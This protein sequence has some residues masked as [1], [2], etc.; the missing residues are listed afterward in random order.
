MPEATSRPESLTS[1]HDDWA[2]LRTVV[3]GLGVTGFSVADTL[4]ELG[5]SVLVIADSASSERRQLL[6]VI[7]GRL[8]L[9]PDG[10]RGLPAMEE[11]VPELVVVSPGYHPDHP[12]LVWAAQAG[13]PI[14]GDIELAWR[15]RDKVGAPAEWISVTGT[16][17]KTTTVGLTAAMLRAHGLRV[18]ACGNIGLPVLDAIRNPDGFDALVVELS[19]YQLHWMRGVSPLASACLNIA[20][21]HLDWHGSAEAYRLAKGR[22]YE[23]TKVACVYNRADAATMQLVEDAEVVEGARAV[24]F[25]LDVPGPSDFGVVDGILVDRAF[26]AERRDSAL[27]IATVPELREQG[28]SAP[29]VVANILAA[30]ALARAAGVSIASIRTALEG[31][32]LDPHRIEKVGER[33]GVL[34]I[35]DSKATNPHAAEA[36]LGA[37]GSVVWIVGGL[38]KGVSIDD[39]VKRRSRGLRAAV[40]IGADR[41]EVIEA[42]GRHAPELPLFEVVPSETEAVMQSAVRMAAS[43]VR[44]G[45]VV[46]LAPAAA[47]MDQFTDYGDRGRAFALAVA[48]HLDAQDTASAATDP[49]DADLK[50]G[51]PDDRSVTGAPTE[52]RHADRPDPSS[53]SDGTESADDDSTGSPTA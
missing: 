15:L 13:I 10:T 11:F 27:E 50:E 16:N 40:V 22:V 18:A 38:L 9:D 17:G 12:L 46:L 49:A 44:P 35:D 6:K 8:L 29:H 39:L 25:G 30:S 47:S 1:W 53:G 21:D 51:R 36:S 19:S 4:V 34:W 43:V 45:D 42:F 26:L 28:L 37:F 14:W 33:D 20:D 41:T 3:L 31:Y 32:R 23:N 2:G 24:G 48:Q 7:G 5:S 52:P